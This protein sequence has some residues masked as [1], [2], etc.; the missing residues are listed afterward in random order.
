MSETMCCPLSSCDDYATVYDVEERTARK[1]HQCY[2]CCG[3]I[4]SRARYEHISMLFDGKWD[5]F[6][7]CLLCREIGDHFACGNGRTLGTLWSDLEE[8]FYPDMKAGG[9]CMDGLSP[10]AKHL[11]IDR[12]MAWYFDQ[13]EI[14]DQ[15]W[16]GWTPDK[17][18]RPL[19]APTNDARTVL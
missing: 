19:L 7:L 9:P 15:Q 13:D 11:L 8:N 10:A 12:R 6:R 5:S 3:A 1:E 2:E 4:P 16:D 17:P 18:P 14:D